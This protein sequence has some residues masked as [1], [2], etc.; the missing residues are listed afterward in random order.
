MERLFFPFA[1]PN[2]FESELN[3]MSPTQVSGF[4]NMWHP[5]YHSYDEHRVAQSQKCFVLPRLEKLHFLCVAKVDLKL[6]KVLPAHDCVH[7]SK[8]QQQH[9]RH[10]SVELEHLFHLFWGS[11]KL[12]TSGPCASR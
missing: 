2:A 9:G 10:C 3:N 1:K 8:K 7:R 5:A 4:Q 11:L 6:L 12:H